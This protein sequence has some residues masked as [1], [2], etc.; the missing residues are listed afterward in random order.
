MAFYHY[1]KDYADDEN[2][3][4]K[5]DWI[6]TRLLTLR[7]DLYTAIKKDRRPNSLIIGSWNIRAF[8]DGVPRLNILDVQSC[9]L[10]DGEGPSDLFGLTF[11]Q[12]FALDR[13]HEHWNG[14]V[15]CSAAVCTC[16]SVL[17]NL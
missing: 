2:Y 17:C 4:N 8:D 3:P 14:R 7:H 9:Q 15:S 10:F 16:L 13:N 1:L 6:A 11:L 12:V 5:Q